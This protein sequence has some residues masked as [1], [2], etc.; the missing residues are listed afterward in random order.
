M[1]KR[2]SSPECRRKESVR[3]RAGMT[4]RRSS[5]HYRNKEVVRDRH[6]RAEKRKRYDYRLSIAPSNACLQKKG[7]QASIIQQALRGTNSF[8]DTEWICDTCLRS[9]KKSVLP[10]LALANGLEFTV[11]PLPLVG[12]TTLEERCISPRIPFMQL[13]ELRRDRQFGIMGNVANV[14]VD[15]S[16]TVTSLPMRFADAEAVALK[17]KR[18]IRYKSSFTLMTLHQMASKH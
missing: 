10:Y 4:K 1:T 13:R 18:R 6:R 8:Q 9:V 15:V 12:L 11:I 2:R 3:N 17:L 16:A 5:K 14:P 7:V